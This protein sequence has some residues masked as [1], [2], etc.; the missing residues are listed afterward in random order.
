MND[1]ELRWKMH[2]A[3]ER[4]RVRRLDALQMS[5]LLA[6]QRRRRRTMFGAGGSLGV[7]AV[8][9]LFVLAISGHGSTPPHPVITEPTTSLPPTT[10][11]RVTPA[12]TTVPGTTPSSSGPR[13]V[14]I[15]QP[16][17]GRIGTSSIQATATLLGIEAAQT[18]TLEFDVSQGPYNTGQP[19]SAESVAVHGPGTYTMPVPYRPRQAGSWYVTV[20]FGFTS[21]PG[22]GLQVSGMP[23]PNN[24][25]RAPDLST[26]ITDAPLPLIAIGHWRGREPVTIYFSADGGNIA[27]NLN[28]FRWSADDATA[29]GT[30]HYLNC[31]PSCA[32][33]TST[34][35][36]V[37]I[38]LTDAVNGQFTKLREQTSGPHAFTEIF[39]AP[40]LAQ[41]ACTNQNTNSC[42]FAY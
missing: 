30:W 41:G 32:A 20:V 17:S 11:L 29:T 10:T 36:P 22:A 39:N 27:T 6:R 26:T 38:T 40:H 8:I 31:Q 3:A 25:H 12:P 37:T 15:S 23:S 14:A 9:A 16:R 18:G 7:V 34:P 5:R 21:G 33:G 13:L 35:Y 4:I 42:A 19:A 28:W 24:P 1:E 2:R